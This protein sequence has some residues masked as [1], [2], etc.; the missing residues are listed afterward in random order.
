MQNTNT[1]QM[2]EKSVQNKNEEKMNKIH[3]DLAVTNTPSD[4]A[5]HG[6]LHKNEGKKATTEDYGTGDG[7]SNQ[8][9][10]PRLYSFMFL[11][12]LPSD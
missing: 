3:D 2:L 4:E 11:I 1:S 8:E 12:S 7:I 9:V 10:N 6:N 5:T